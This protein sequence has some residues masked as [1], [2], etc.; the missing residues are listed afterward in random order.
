M[1]KAHP[2]ELRER[3]VAHVEEA[4]RTGPQPCISRFR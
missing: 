1:V 2:I 3:V 4:I